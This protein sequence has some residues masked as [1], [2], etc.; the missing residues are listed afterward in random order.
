MREKL[1]ICGEEFKK[2][3]THFSFKEL[4]KHIPDMKVLKKLR[5]FPKLQSV[6]LNGT[7]INDAGLKYLSECKTI[8][9]LNVTFTGITDKGIAHL[10]ALDK[11]E[12]LRLKDTSIS[13]KSISHFNKIRSLISLQVHETDITGKHLSYLNLP[14]LEEAFV[15]CDDNEDH[16]TLLLFSARMENCRVYVKGRGYYYRHKFYG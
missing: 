1:I 13:F 9:N 14:Q 3:S 10:T 4:Y 16:E 12:H 11:L 2:S 5:E 6:S 15:D 7:N 8:T